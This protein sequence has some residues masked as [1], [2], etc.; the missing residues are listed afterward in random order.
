MVI[1]QSENKCC[2]LGEMELKGYIYFSK[3]AANS[4][5][6][7][8]SFSEDDFHRLRLFPLCLCRVLSTFS[9]IGHSE[10]HGMA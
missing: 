5:V 8:L 1:Q 10:R 2:Q 4:R 6:F 9:F 7:N 3:K